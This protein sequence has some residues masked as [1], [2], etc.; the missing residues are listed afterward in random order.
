LAYFK[1][2]LDDSGSFLDVGGH[3]FYV[4]KPFP[5]EVTDVLDP[6]CDTDLDGSKSSNFC[7]MVEVLALEDDGGGDPPCYMPAARMPTSIGTRSSTSRAG[8]VG[9]S[10]HRPVR[11][12]RP[13]R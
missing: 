10:H 13:H 9:R 8:R 12:T 6:L 5:E 4:V 7:T 3:C 2:G 1:D 11:S